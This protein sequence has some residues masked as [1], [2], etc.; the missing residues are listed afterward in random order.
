[1][2]LPHYSPMSSSR[3]LKNPDIMF[4]DL[5]LLLN[6]SIRVSDAILVGVEINRVFFR[7]I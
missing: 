1:M 2:V 4:F 7:M 3:V 6:V 5:T